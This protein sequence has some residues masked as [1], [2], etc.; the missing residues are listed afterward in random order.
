MSSKSRICDTRL[1]ARIGCGIAALLM[2]A[3][4][5]AV[6]TPSSET[7]TLAMG[8]PVIRVPFMKNCRR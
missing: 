3:P 4:A 8:D 6:E 7:H 5:Q 1:S 2:L